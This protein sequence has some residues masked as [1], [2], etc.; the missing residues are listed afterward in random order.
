MCRM[1]LRS[2]YNSASGPAVYASYS[3]ADHVYTPSSGGVRASNKSSIEYRSMMTAWFSCHL[4]KRDEVCALFEGNKDSEIAEG[5]GWS[6]IECKN[7]N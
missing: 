4:Q 6:V 1:N 3:G 2:L 5:A 7:M